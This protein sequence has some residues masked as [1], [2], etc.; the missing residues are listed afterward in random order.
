[1]KEETSTNFTFGIGGKWVEILTLD[2][3]SINLKDRVV[4][5]TEIGSAAGN[6]ALDK[7]LTDNKWFKFFTNAI[8]TKTSG[9]DLVITYDKLEVGD[10]K[11]GFNLSGNYVIENARD[12]AVNNPAIVEAAGQSVVNDTQEALFFTSRPEMKFILGVNYDIGK[13]DSILTTPILVKRNLLNKVYK[14]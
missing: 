7:I 14:I 13:F 11:L 5:S 6:T 2:Y 9:L 1:L 10:G 4:L 12:G 8:D 3:Y